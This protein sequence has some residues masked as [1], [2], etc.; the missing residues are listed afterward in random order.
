MSQLLTFATANNC[1]SSIGASETSAAHPVAQGARSIKHSTTR[2]PTAFAVAPATTVTQAITLSRATDPF[3]TIYDGYG[4]R[5]Q[6]ANTPLGLPAVSASE[7]NAATNRFINTGATPTTYDAA[8]NITIDTKFRGL[9]Y[10]Y[11]ANGRQ[12]AA[13]LLDN[14]TIQTSV[15]DCAGQRIQTTANGVTRTMIYDVFGQNV[16][17]YLGS[18]LERENIYRGG[19][20]LATETA[21]PSAA[22]PT[23]LTASPNTGGTNISLSWSAASG[24]TR[25]RIERRSAGGNFALLGTTTSTSFTDTTVSSGSAYLYKICSADA[26]NNCTSSY[27]NL[28]LGTAVS[29]T[30]PTIISIADDPTGATVTTV[31]AAHIN[32][33]RFAVNAVRS[34]AGL[35]TASWTYSSVT[36]GSTIHVE[37]VRDLRTNLDQAL[38]ALNIQTSAYTDATLVG[39]A[40]NPL[41]ATTI[42]AVHIR[43]LRD[44]AKAGVGSTGSSGSGA[45][46]AY[47]LS[48][49]Q[50]STRAILNNNGSNSTVVARHDYLPFGEEIGAG[51][52]LR[53]AGQGFNA[54][55]P[56]RWKYALTERDSSTG[57]DNTWWRKYENFSG[58]WTTP[59]P[60]L[61]SM[62]LVNPQSFNRYPYVQN[63]PV[64]FIDPTG[65][66]LLIIRYR[67]IEGVIEIL[68]IDLVLCND[69]RTR[70][71][72]GPG[73]GDTPGGGPGGAVPRGPIRS[74]H[75]QKHNSEFCKSLLQKIKNIREQIKKRQEEFIR[76]EQRLPLSVP[77]GRLRDDQVGH[78]KIMIDL[79]DTLARRMDEYTNR[80]G[81]PPPGVPPLVPI[82]PRG[83][84]VQAPRPGFRI[85]RDQATAAAAGA[86]AAVVT[87]FIIRSILRVAFPPSNLVPA[88]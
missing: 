70:D 21:T 88:P 20:L 46:L 65:L 71:G 34:L 25:Y 50:G 43:E 54:S 24:A 33:L 29:F 38:A 79:Y 80:C 52:G 3:H 66:C 64:N 32:E 67:F 53:T 35:S 82:Q 42:K 83:P 63:D 2:L 7:I 44:R 14:T 4:N 19:Q 61:G 36:I 78:I 51:V 18:S 72:G 26:Q 62:S 55:D 69:G 56:N 87:Y 6:S 57:L 28:A 81:G 12:T 75:A 17:D 48:D 15:Y 77:G 60:Y 40:E 49:I 10:E 31:K 9:K 13:K 11:D 41:N 68:D 73:G 84:A 59:D 16:A 27:S 37:D 85:T 5:F 74:H 22:A 58:R 76:N 23:G 86:G 45:G 1:S 30:D 39:Y 8:G 47:I